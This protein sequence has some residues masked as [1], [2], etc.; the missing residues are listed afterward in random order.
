MKKFTLISLLVLLMLQSGGLFLLLKLEQQFVKREMETELNEDSDRLTPLSLSLEEFS[1][2]R[3]NNHELKFHG[4]MLDFK[5]VGY[6]HNTVSLLV[7]NDTEEDSII[8]HL[9]TFNKLTQK[10]QNKLPQH[11]VKLMKQ[12]FLFEKSTFSPEN[13]CNFRVINR[14]VI[15]DIIFGDQEIN[16]PPP[17]H[18]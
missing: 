12:C 1:Q 16:S 3:L 10:Q 5:I 7:L 2:C 4:N 13:D 18:V 9:S 14:E 11:M 8:H 15:A 6:N 17:K